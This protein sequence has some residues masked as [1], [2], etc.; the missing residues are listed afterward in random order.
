MTFWKNLAEIVQAFTT[1]LALLVAGIWT[2]LLFIRQRLG[3]PKLDMDL[4]IDDVTLPE[5]QR[6]VHAQLRLTNVGGVVVALDR[7]ELRLRQVVPIIDKLKPVIVAGYDPVPDGKTE[8]EWPMIAGRE[9][10]WKAGEFEIEPGESDF[11]H[12]DFVIPIE[13]QIAQCYC[14]VNNA[15]KKRQGI[16]WTLT[17]ICDFRL[18]EDREMPSSKNKKAKVVSKKPKM[19]Q[20]QQQKQQKPQQQQQQLQPKKKKSK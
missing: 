18:K 7:A 14:F 15:S 16:G 11:I 12:T 10:A 6:F 2:Y 9:W 1:S 5:G 8:I 3:F 17:R 20:Q 13:I 19:Y 4:A